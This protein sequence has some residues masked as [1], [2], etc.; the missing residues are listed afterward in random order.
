[1]EIRRYQIQD[2]IPQD[3]IDE[4]AQD[5]TNAQVKMDLSKPE[6]RRST[7]RPA[8]ERLVN[9]PEDCHANPAQERDVT[10]SRRPGTGDLDAA[11]KIMSQ[12]AVARQQAK[13]EK[14]CT[15]AYESQ[16]QILHDFTS[17]I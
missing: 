12:R 11:V 15:P 14:A 17:D 10:V 13:D 1:M 5:G 2:P 3:S 8:R 6:L 16:C 4:H 7:I 9:E